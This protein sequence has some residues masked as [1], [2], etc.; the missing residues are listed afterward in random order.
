MAIAAHVQ[1]SIE[2]GRFEE[3]E[4]QWLAHLESSPEDVGFF[5][6]LARALDEG[7]ESDRLGSLL[8]LADEHLGAAGTWQAR[9]ELLR[10]VAALWLPDERIHPEIVRTLEAIYDG[11]PSYARLAEHVG[12][13][14]AIGDLDKIWTKVDRLRTLLSYEVGSIVWMEGQGAGRVAEINMALESFRIDFDGGGTVT[15]GFGGAGKLLEPV[16]AGH[17]IHRRLTEPRELQALKKSDPPA[18]LHLVLDSYDEPLTA[19][20]VREALGGVVAESEWSSWWAAARRHPHLVVSGKGSRQRYGLASSADEAL[21]E[22]ERR[23]RRAELSDKLAIFR[24]NA[25]RDPA[26]RQKMEAELLALGAELAATEPAGAMAIWAELERLGRAP[27]GA[28]WSPRALLAAAERP[29]ELVLDIADRGRRVEA[30]GMLKESHEEWRRLFAELMARERDPRVLDRLA[31]ELEREDPEALAA[32]IER[33]L[34]EPRKLPWALVWLGERAAA[35]LELA[36]RQALKLLQQLFLAPRYPQFAPLRSRLDSLYEAGGPFPRLIAALDEKLAPQA[37]RAVNRAPLDTAVRKALSQALE[38]RFPALRAR[39]VGAL[40]ALDESIAAKRLEMRRLLEEEI[41]ANRRAIETARE[42]GDLRENF[43]YKAARQRHEYL[44][45]RAEKLQGDL[46]RARPIEA[47][48][49][50]PMTVRIGC[51]VELEDESGTR[52]LTILG[53]WESDPDRSI[54][55]YES[56]L[57]QRILGRQ[58]G[59]RVPLSEGPARVSGIHPAEL[60][61]PA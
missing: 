33:A 57:A 18:L 5:A 53:P 48:E 28:D 41:P 16:P 20:K 8:E 40:Y 50:A 3:V 58:V 26:L 35:D 56:E 54:I 4:D 49:G 13:F 61:G 39:G 22:A 34:N 36:P 23:F 44:A 14:R 12:L 11:S 45:A 31:S 42:M 32:L 55:S 60:G 9:L 1:Q 47:I 19:G 38:L 59:D 2:A 17:V 21:A 10:E 27:E 46:Q 43:E 7:G 37:A 30:V 15:V 51:R 25:D 29:V 24:K 52:S 6:E